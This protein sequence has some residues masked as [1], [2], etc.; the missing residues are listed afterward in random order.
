MK[1]TERN[2]L[3]QEPGDC[4]SWPVPSPPADFT[5][6]P[7]SEVPISEKHSLQRLY[8][9][10]L[11]RVAR[12]QRISA[13]RTIGHFGRLGVVGEIKPTI[14]CYGS[15]YAWETRQ[16]GLTAVARLTRSA[17]ESSVARVAFQTRLAR[18]ARYAWIAPV[19]WRSFGA[20]PSW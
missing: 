7:I 4:K 12:P 5:Q 17:V 11:Q 2:S 19:T 20:L 3:M 14:G 6:I 18:S 1:G 9:A 15:H 16:T 8:D 10:L 13:S